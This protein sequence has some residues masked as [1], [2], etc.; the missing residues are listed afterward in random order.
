MPVRLGQ[1]VSNKEWNWGLIGPDLLMEWLQSWVTYNFFND[2]YQDAEHGIRLWS[3]PGA[4]WTID[5]SVAG[6]DLEGRAFTGLDPRTEGVTKITVQSDGKSLRMSCGATELSA[7]LGAFMEWARPPSRS[8][9]RDEEW[10]LY[11]SGD[12]VLGWLQTWYAQQCDG[13]WERSHSIRLDALDNPGWLF[14]ADLRDT[15]LAGRLI[16]G[17]QVE[18]S[19]HDWLHV[20]PGVDQFEVAAGPL[21]LGEALAAFR[22]W[23]VAATAKATS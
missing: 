8:A 18:R 13:S 11:E 4:G 2:D 22:D 12:F 10:C 6:T 3:N 21:N 16:E 9:E 14:T 23:A 19:V 17:R 1:V 7:A 20:R 5:I 15:E